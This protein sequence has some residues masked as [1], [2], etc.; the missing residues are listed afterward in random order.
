MVLLYIAIACGPLVILLVWLI[1]RVHVGPK[2]LGRGPRYN[3]KHGKYCIMYP[4]QSISSRMCRD[5]ARFVANRSSGVVIRA[6]RSK[7][8]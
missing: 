2:G 4:D 5:T 3:L 1:Y 8:D 6:Q 7:T